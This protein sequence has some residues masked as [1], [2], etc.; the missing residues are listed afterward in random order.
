MTAITITLNGITTMPT[1]K[2][3]LLPVPHPGETL[4]ED[5]MVPLGLSAYAV[6]KAVGSTPITISM[7]C[8][9]MRSVSAEMAIRLGR[10]TGTSP[11]FW[12]GLQSFYDLRV[13]RQAKEAEINLRVAPFEKA[14]EVV[15]SR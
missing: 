12:M 5:F 9:G 3:N 11:E 15:C 7:I 8:R 4:K 1:K 13:A 6:A 10:F 14:A 2:N